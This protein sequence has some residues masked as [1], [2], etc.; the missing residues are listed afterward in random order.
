MERNG[1]ESEEKRMERKGKEGKG[2]ERMNRK[3]KEGKGGERRTDG[4]K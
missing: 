1:Q 2:G 4:R 3:G